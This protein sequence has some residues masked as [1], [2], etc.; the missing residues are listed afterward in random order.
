M[1]YQDLSGGRTLQEDL[2]DLNVNFFHNQNKDAGIKRKKVVKNK[3]TVKQ[4]LIKRLLSKLTASS[5]LSIL[6]F[7]VGGPIG[8]GLGAALGVFGFGKKYKEIVKKTVVKNG[9]KT[10][11]EYLNG[12]GMG[13]DLKKLHDTYFSD[14]ALEKFISQKDLM[15]AAFIGAAEEEKSLQWGDEEPNRE[16]I[17]NNQKAMAQVKTHLESAAKQLNGIAEK[18]AVKP[19]TVA[20]F[21]EH[22]YDWGPLNQFMIKVFDDTKLF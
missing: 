17:I 4:G 9:Y 20:N 13:N 6:G 16:D 22:L 10:I 2:S 1:K 3:T 11:D 5:I 21:Y 15:K 8:A 14:S 12:T 18:Y 19:A 7:A